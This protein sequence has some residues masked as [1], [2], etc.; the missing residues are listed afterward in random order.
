VVLKLLLYESPGVLAVQNL[1]KG[2]LRDEEHYAARQ[3]QL[4]QEQR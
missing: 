1:H 2:V 3:A 4:R